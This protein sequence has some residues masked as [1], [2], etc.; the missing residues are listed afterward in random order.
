MATSF[1][2]TLAHLLAVANATVVLFACQHAGAPSTQSQGAQTVRRS[3]T[4]S[5][6]SGWAPYWSGPLL[7]APPEE[8]GPSP[9]RTSVG[10]RY[11]DAERSE[12]HQAVAIV[13]MIVDT[14]GQVIVPTLR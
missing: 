14:A 1:R 8:N 3:A 9:F 4:I 12:G 2:R 7:I 5:A 11:P 10:P 13:A 6:D